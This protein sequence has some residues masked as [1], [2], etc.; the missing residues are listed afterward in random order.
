M[1][2]DPENGQVRDVQIPGIWRSK[3][4]P[5]FGLLFQPTLCLALLLSF[6][7]SFFFLL[8]LLFFFILS[9]CMKIGRY[10]GG[11][12]FWND[13]RFAFSKFHFEDSARI[14]CF[15]LHFFPLLF[16]PTL[17][18]VL[19]LPFRICCFDLSRADDISK[20]S[21][22]F[23]YSSGSRLCRPCAFHKTGES[24]PMLAFLDHSQASRA[25][26][27]RVRVCWIISAVV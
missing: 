20:S 23:R 2:R 9:L 4:W 18:L 6:H 3:R 7:F 11:R 21:F 12:R 10:G 27:G 25:P 26:P 22:T 8:C 13:A 24:F 14:A 19:I 5:S 16:Q 15:H 17:C 1:T